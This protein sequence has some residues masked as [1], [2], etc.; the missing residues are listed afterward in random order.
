MNPR[1]IVP[2][3]I[4]S[5]SAPMFQAIFLPLLF[6]E[7]TE[8]GYVDLAFDRLAVQMGIAQPCNRCGVFPQEKDSAYCGK[9]CS[10]KSDTQH[11][12]DSSSNGMH[13]S[14]SYRL[15]LRNTLSP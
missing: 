5:Q 13:L 9:T 6:A 11:D 12:D 15:T 1:R 10:S 4:E 8:T 3:F 14:S 2:K 7:G